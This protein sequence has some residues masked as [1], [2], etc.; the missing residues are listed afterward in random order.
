[1]PKTDKFIAY[2]RVSTARQGAS[3]LGLDA[4]RK[5]IEDYLA[6]YGGEIISPEYLE[7][8]SG[9]RKSRP[10]LREAIEH[11]RRNDAILLVAKLDRLA[12][13]LAFITQL[14]EAKVR[15]RAC[16]MP[17]ANEFVIHIL[18]A[19]AEYERKMISQRTK[20]GLAAAKRRG[21]RLGKPENL[22]HG[23]G[24]PAKEWNIRQKAK[25]LERAERLRPVILEILKTDNSI[26]GLCRQLNERGY[27]SST[28]SCW[29][30]ATVSKLLKRLH[31]IP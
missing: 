28:N 14:Q 12:R 18:G 31:I 25:A 30:P 22:I 6:Q 19:V 27:L 9:K 10:I 15:F 24:D 3:G 11:A 21:V 29:H 26:R 16:D 8:E 2:L 23:L 1:M 4:Q 17:E 13:N 7:V 5:A 20:D